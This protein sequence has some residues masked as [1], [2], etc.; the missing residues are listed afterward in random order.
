MTRQVL[1]GLALAF[2]ALQAQAGVA[3]IGHPGIAAAGLTADQAA[4]LYL[5]KSRTLP[6]GSAATVIDLKEGDPARVFFLERVVGKDEQQVRG[7]WAR[8]IFS[9]KG[10]PP[11]AVGSGAEMLRAVEATPGAVGII[12]SAQVTGRVKVLYRID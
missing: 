10:Q 1:A 12:D 3:V 5:G 9:G 6:D 2:A 7:Y 11:R 8:Q 4:Q